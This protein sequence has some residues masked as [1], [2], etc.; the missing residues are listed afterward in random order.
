MACVVFTAG[1]GSGSDSGEN[2]SAQIVAS[3]MVHK[4]PTITFAKYY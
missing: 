2:S 1:V 4:A 3:T